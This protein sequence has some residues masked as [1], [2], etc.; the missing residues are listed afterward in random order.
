MIILQESTSTDSKSGGDPYERDITEL[1]QS[2]VILVNKPRGPT[3]H[4]LAS[5]ARNLLGIKKL[6]HG[7]TLDPFAT[8]VLTLLC[9]RAT[10]L[11]DIVLSGE[12]RYVGVMRF[13][14]DVDVE[15][16]TSSLSSLVGRSYNVPPKESAVK[17]RVRS[18]IFN[19]IELLDFDPKSR[20]FVIEIDCEAGTYIRTL[21]RDLGLMVGSNCQLIELHR[22]KAGT[23]DSSMACS[24]Q[25]LTDALHVYREHGDE[26]G[27]RRLICPIER[28]LTHLPRIVVKDGAAAALSHGATLARPGAV[29]VSAGAKAGSTVL[30]ETLKGEAVSIAELTVDSEAFLEIDSGE[31][32]IPMS[33]LMS[34][35]TYP[36]TWSKST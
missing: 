10:R 5:W 2:G 31:I 16:V 24:M 4:Q 8:G 15:K 18:R 22:T 29:K 7:G 28:L 12:K 34:P 9:G 1:F 32:A 30:I 14:K 6:G 36:Q 27:L 21:A 25:Q 23:F 11:T 19:S 20:I 35:G 3:S 17:V 26:R 33:V 13:S